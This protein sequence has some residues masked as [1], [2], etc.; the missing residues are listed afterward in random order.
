LEVSVNL[1]NLNLQ[2]LE[3]YRTSESEKH[4]RVAGYRVSNQNFRM[5]I[6][7]ISIMT[8]VGTMATAKDTAPPAPPNGVRIKEN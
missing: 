5:T 2:S 8:L 4:A 1:K 7:S 6:P 3:A